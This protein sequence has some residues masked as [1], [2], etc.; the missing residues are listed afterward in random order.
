M[1]YDL[2]Q[3][4]LCDGHPGIICGKSMYDYNVLLLTGEMKANVEAYRLRPRPVEI[5][6]VA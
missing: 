2:R 4:V 6:G 1:T 5:R 3:P